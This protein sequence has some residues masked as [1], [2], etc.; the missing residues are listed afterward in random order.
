MRLL[1]PDS[2]AFHCAPQHKALSYTINHRRI[3]RLSL[4]C[5]AGQKHTE[6]MR[7]PP[8]AQTDGK[9]SH[10][11]AFS[12]IPANAGAAAQSIS[13]KCF[14]RCC[15]LNFPSYNLSWN[16]LLKPASNCGSPPDRRSFRICLPP[17]QQPSLFVSIISESRKIHNVILCSKYV[18]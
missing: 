6:R 18:Q 15:T 3:K 14:F 12:I 8:I 9:R 4:L 7:Q 16:L 11:P 13:Q 10:Q 5:R 1:H 17:K 2:A